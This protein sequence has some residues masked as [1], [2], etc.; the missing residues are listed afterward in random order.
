MAENMTRDI[1]TANMVTARAMN[2][3]FT[4]DPWI[5]IEQQSVQ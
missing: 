4:H 2:K 1:K 3:K 5:I